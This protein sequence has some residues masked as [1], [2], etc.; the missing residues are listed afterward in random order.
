MEKQS[1]LKCRRGSCRSH[2]SSSRLY[3]LADQTD[4]PSQI[5]LCDEGRKTDGEEV[6]MFVG[7]LGGGDIEERDKA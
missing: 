3:G 1:D 7:E 4:R 6:D 5:M 2:A